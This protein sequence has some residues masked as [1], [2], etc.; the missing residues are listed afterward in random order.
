M[1]TSLARKLVGAL[2]AGAAALGAGQAQAFDWGGVTAHVVM[3]EATYMPTR[4]TFIVDQPAGTC[5]AGQV[6]GWTSTGSDST[7][8]TA[9]GS[10]VLSLLMTAQVSG[11]PIT[12]FGYNSGC[13]VAFI[14]LGSI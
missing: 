5:A 2:A 1:A 11:R 9:Q 3:V 10:A 12:I 8:L 13:S 14:H 4:V 6:L 7:Q